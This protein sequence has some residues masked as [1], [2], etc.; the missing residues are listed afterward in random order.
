M[1][2]NGWTVLLI[3]G[4]TALFVY[5]WATNREAKRQAD[6]A[7]RETAERVH[8]RLAAEV[9][10]ALEAA[11]QG[12]GLGETYWELPSRVAVNTPAP[13]ILEAGIYRVQGLPD[14]ALAA[15]R[16]TD[17]GWE[18]C[19]ITTG[20]AARNS[21][22]LPSEQ[23]RALTKGEVREKLGLELWSRRDEEE[24]LRAEEITI[25]ARQTHFDLP[26]NW[27]GTWRA[28]KFAEIRWQFQEVT[29]RLAALGGESDAPF[30]E[31]L[32]LDR[33]YA[34]RLLEAKAYLGYEPDATDLSTLD[35]E[36]LKRVR[37]AMDAHQ[38]STGGMFDHDA[39][40]VCKPCQVALDQRVYEAWK[41]VNS[42]G[43]VEQILIDRRRPHR[44][45]DGVCRDCGHGDQHVRRAAKQAGAKL[46][47]AEAKLWQAA[48]GGQDHSC[49]DC[50]EQKQAWADRDRRKLDHER[51]M[52]TPMLP[53]CEFCKPELQREQRARVLAAHA[54]G[55]HESFA[56]KDKSEVTECPECRSRQWEWYEANDPP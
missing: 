22:F 56:Y 6:V 18:P 16:L 17:V 29:S 14:A 55:E 32:A 27:S 51:G 47:Q 50:Q 44:I 35:P 24:R 3:A 37:H 7:R 48:H 31:L 54:G 21:F 28:A 13:V 42:P 39:N 26:A 2:V 19:D 11:G 5:P 4:P 46:R 1:D 8:A 15:E 20:R 10:D 45:E 53:E 30:N 25:I 23:A 40:G 9:E 34:L 41:R 36:E 49:P 12:G 43:Q 33:G 38:P 52:H